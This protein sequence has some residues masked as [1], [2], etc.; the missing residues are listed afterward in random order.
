MRLSPLL[1]RYDSILLDLDGCVRVGTAATPRADEAIA[2]LR[3]AGKGIA[4]VTNDPSLSPEDTVRQLWGLGV[5]ASVLEVVTVGGALQQ[6]LAEAPG[7]RNA[8]V[9]GSAAIHRHVELAGV[10]IL[11]HTDM[12]TRADVVIVAGHD[13][14]DYGTLRI[15]TQAVLEGAH[16]ICAG[17]DRTFPMPDGFW[18]GTGAMVSAVEFATG[19]RAESVGKPEAPIF[20]TALERAGNGAALMIGDNIAADVAG[21]HGIG[22][23]AAVVLSGQATRADAE[24]ALDGDRPIVGIADTL[25]DLVLVP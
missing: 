17:R 18:P 20:R 12:A 13:N 9:I 8:F 2:A 23:D 1:Q 22:I 21:A 6:S 3:Q 7:L 24:A 5:R 15:A 25:A 14:F 10:G 4:F 11:N 19:R 16:L